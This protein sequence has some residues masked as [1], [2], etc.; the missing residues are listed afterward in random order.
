MPQLDLSPWPVVILSMIMTLF[1]II[2]L[3]MLNFTFYITPLS[4]LTKMQKHKTTWEL[5]WTKIYL[6]PSMC[7]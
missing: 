5:K 7:Q 3:K 1:Y 4:K 2:Q 6:P